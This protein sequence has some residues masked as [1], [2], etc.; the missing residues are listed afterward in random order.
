MSTTEETVELIDLD[1]PEFENVWNLVS[2]TSRSIFMTGKA[3][4]G[5]STF[6]KYITSHTKKKFVVLAPTGIAAVNVGGVT[7]HSFF[8]IPLKPLL[9]DDPDFAVERIKKRLKY[10]REH[11]KLIRSLDLIIIDEISMVR[12][13]VIDFMDKILRVY[14]GKRY[15]PFGGKQ[16]L[17]VGDIFQLEP[18]VTGDMRDILSRY[19][20]N[21]FFFSARA[22]RE[23]PLIP[24]ELRKIYRQHDVEFISLLDRVRVG[25]PTYH[26]L[27]KLKTRVNPDAECGSDDFVMTLASRRDM[28]DNINDVRLA[29]LKS[30]KITYTGT[31]AEEFSESALPVPIQLTLKVGAQVVFIRNDR[32]HRWVNGTLGKVSSATK[33]RLEIELENGKCHVVQPE[34]WENIEYSYDEENHKI[35]EK[36]LGTYTQYPIRL[37][38]ALTVHKSQGLTFSKVIIDLGRGAFSSGQ[39][40]VALSR[41]TGLEGLTLKSALTARDIFVNN[42][43]TDYTRVFNND[44]MISAAINEARAD[45]L[46]RAAAVAF[47][48]GDTS[49]AVDKFVAAL[50]ARNELNNAVV[51]RLLKVKLASIINMKERIKYLESEANVVQD[52]FN[53]LASEYV[54]MGDD[55]LKAGDCAAAVANYEK[56]MSLNP[57]H[58]S[59]IIGHARAMAERGDLDSA[60]SGY[61]RV[62]SVNGR[63]YDASYELAELYMHSGEIYDAL[64]WY[65]NALNIDETRADLLLKLAELY[66]SIGDDDEAEFYRRKARK[67]KRK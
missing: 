10:S 20:P 37:A 17:L 63:N 26:D 38:W 27:E 35:I 57:R 18:V 67:L 54:I 25:A 53:D 34:V 51:L 59:A 47:N 1:N 48:G 4:T 60:I 33:S 13:D 50:N 44:R 8:K 39:T 23:F 24:I 31:I 46:Y 56:A 64:N 49:L 2:H 30:K 3:G 40:Y 66:D 11:Q 32:E 21:T 42:A 22:F 65:L 52:R 61:K 16:L 29:R 5:K 14:T 12:A 55:C 58:E 9:P 43:I 36:V 15:E 62:L 19:Y 6:L 41:C 7:M 28:V 45:A